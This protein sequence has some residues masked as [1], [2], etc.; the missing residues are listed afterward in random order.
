MKSRTIIYVLTLTGF[1]FLLP[2][3]QIQAQISG[4]KFG[5][6]SVK[7]IENISLYR[8]FFN[9]WKTSKHKNEAIKDAIPYWRWVYVNCPKA[10]ERTFLDGVKMYQFFVENEK[11]DA[12]KEKLIDTLMQIYD[13]RLSLFVK[14]KKKRGDILSRKGYDYYRYR[15]TDFETAYKMYKESVDLMKEKS[16]SSTLNVYFRLTRKMVKEEVAD[17]SLIFDTYDEIMDIINKNLATGKRVEMWKNLKGNVELG[18]E[19]YAKCEDIVEL[20]GKKLEEHPD[21]IELLKKAITLLDKK[22]CKDDP[23]YYNSVVQLYNLEPSPESA[24]FIA[25]WNMS[26][27]SFR[28]AINYLQKSLEIKDEEKL[29]DIHMYIAK[30]Y[31]QLKN[32]RSARSSARQAIKLDSKRADAVM[33]IGDCYASTAKQIGD[34]ELTSRVAYWAAVDKYERAKRIDPSMA[35]QLNKRIRDYTKQF[36][37]M[38][39]IFFH[40]LETGQEYLVE[41]WIQE[42][43]K[44]RAAPEIK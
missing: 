39:N 44:V 40:N 9:Q 29:V 42:K 32:Y 11:D 17:V 30:C 25:K 22:D 10:K 16:K 14:G 20:Y 7:C 37:T 18:F 26:E 23:L 34:N 5:K 43:T 41:G 3:I 1:L 6:D 33:L 36:P 8:E 15:I 24:Y 2:D 31:F 28:E 27:G 38:D 13:T 19:E 4:A 21:N 12:K 35:D